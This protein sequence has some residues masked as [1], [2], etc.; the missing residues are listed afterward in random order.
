MEI[1]LIDRIIDNSIRANK[2]A[3]IEADLN[4]L[5]ENQKDLLR[6]FK[7]IVIHLAAARSDEETEGV[8]E[9]DNSKATNGLLSALDGEK[10]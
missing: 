3:C 7:G 2:T 4:K 6:D 5:S 8:D 9:R 1:T 10:T